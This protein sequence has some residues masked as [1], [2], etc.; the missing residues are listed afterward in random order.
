MTTA[1]LT[2]HSQISATVLTGTMPFPLPYDAQP[3]IL[4]IEFPDLGFGLSASIAD[5][6]LRSEEVA[7]EVLIDD[8]H[9]FFSLQ[10][11]QDKN[12]TLFKI[13][14]VSLRFALLEERPQP[15]FILSTLVALFGLSTRVNLQIAEADLNLDLSFNL[16]LFEISKFLQRRQT[17]YR[18]MIIERATGIEFWLPQTGFSGDEIGLV[19]FIYRAIVERS[20]L[21]SFDSHSFFLPASED[22]LKKLEPLGKPTSRP[23]YHENVEETFLG[24][25]VLLGGMRVIVAEAVVEN[26]DEV[27]KNLMHNDGRPVELVVSSLLGQAR[28][29]FPTAPTL[30]ANSWEPNIQELIDLESKLDAA[31]C[32][33]YNNL[34]AATLSGLTDKQI[35]EVTKRPNINFERDEVVSGGDE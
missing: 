14:S 5:L 8:A 15:D 20:F 30:P 25:S 21:W 35:K 29:E 2:E 7:F 13:E 12:E 4:Q 24:K 18:L 22:T 9:L 17:H 16:P 33:K 26:A 23:F 19:G 3:S 34:A 6:R 27:R 31:L 32:E 10:G 28:Y 11:S 1:A